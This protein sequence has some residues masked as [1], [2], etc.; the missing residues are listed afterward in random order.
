ML[1]GWWVLHGTAWYYMI[2]RM[3]PLQPFYEEFIARAR[4]RFRH[5]RKGEAG[6]KLPPWL[7]Q[8]SFINESDWVVVRWFD[9][10]LSDFTLPSKC[11][12]KTDSRDIDGLGLGKTLAP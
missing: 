12:R 7:E 5:A 2:K 10:V 8:S 9:K 4:R 6:H 1:Y 11:F 3:L